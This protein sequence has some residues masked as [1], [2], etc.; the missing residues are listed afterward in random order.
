MCTSDELA[1]CLE[2]QREECE[3]LEAIYGSELVSFSFVEDDDRPNSSSSSSFTA[4]LKIVLGIELA[5]GGGTKVLLRP[6][7]STS[8]ISAAAGGES[9]SSS[10]EHEP[11]ILHLSHLPP[12]TLTITYP[13]SCPL[14]SP[15]TLLSITTPTSTP[16]LSPSFLQSSLPQLLTQTHLAF[17]PDPSLWTFLELVRTGEFLL[18]P[19]TSSNAG[20]SIEVPTNE[21]NE[22]GLRRLG[23]KLEDW[24]RGMRGE[25]FERTTFECGI[26]LEVKKGKKCLELAGCGHVL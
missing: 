10:S 26:C 13:P 17:A 19:T 20:V 3:S 18:P 24:D 2:L 14:H 21:S 16:Y 8:S 6:R 9:S 15:P 4:E 22:E 5:E 1:I 25:G 11:I 12:L 7:N 23:R